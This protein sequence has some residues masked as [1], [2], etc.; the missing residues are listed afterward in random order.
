M[1]DERSGTDDLTRYQRH[2]SLDEIGMV[3]HE[4]L[5]RARVAVV[6]VGG[7]GSPVA[8]YL[9]VAGVGELRLIDDDTVE[10]SNLNRQLLHATSDL[11]VT[12][13]RSAARR[14]NDL[15]PEC[16]L[17]LQPV[18]LQA[19]NADSLLAGCSLV[20]DCLDSFSSRR[21]LG[22]VCLRL[23][24]PMIHGA[25]RGWEGRLTTIVPGRSPCL[26]CWLP[27]GADEQKPPVLGV[28]P[29]V[30]GALQATEAIRCLL[31]LEPLLTGTLLLYDGRTMMFRRCALEHRSDCPSCGQGGGK[32]T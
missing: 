31:R 2:L 12:K 7:L 17:D 22:E 10:L 16:R 18:R 19:G 13:T 30:I 23:K 8:A 32:P 6:G 14:L 20:V 11:G 9:A 25:V 15:N 29:G 21:L 4:T 5:R 1:V 24:V 26:A 28:V 27:P 3:G